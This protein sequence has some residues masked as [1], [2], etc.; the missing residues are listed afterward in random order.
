[1]LSGSESVPVVVVASAS[2]AVWL[3]VNEDAAVGEQQHGANGNGRSVLSL[4]P[5]CTCGDNLVGS[6]RVFEVNRGR[7]D[8]GSV[9]DNNTARL[10]S[11]EMPDANREEHT[12]DLATE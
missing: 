8:S 9:R 4:C 2:S 3:G 10:A 7:R 12:N 11:R 6:G 1:M 5:G